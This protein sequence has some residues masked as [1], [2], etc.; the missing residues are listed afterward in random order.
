V[1]GCCDCGDEPSGSWATELVSYAKNEEMQNVDRG[2]ESVLYIA[3]MF[4]CVINPAPHRQHAVTAG[5]KST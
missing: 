3:F 5:C 1:A 4:H 2:V